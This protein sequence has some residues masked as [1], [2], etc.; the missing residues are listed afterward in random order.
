MIDGNR[1]VEREVEANTNI[2]L[3]AGRTFVVRAGDAGAVHFFLN[4]R[5]QGAL[6]GEAQVVTRTF[7]AAGASAPPPAR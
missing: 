4:G 2:P 3:P 6:G 5:D 1:A 7:T